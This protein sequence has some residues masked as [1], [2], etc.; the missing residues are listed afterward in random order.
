MS[1]DYKMTNMFPACDKYKIK[2]Y[3]LNTKSITYSI[4]NWEQQP[5]IM[6]QCHVHERNIPASNIPNKQLLNIMQECCAELSNISYII[7]ASS[8]NIK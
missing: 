5:P 6:K 1:H 8:T 7:T 2:Y 4:Q 3:T